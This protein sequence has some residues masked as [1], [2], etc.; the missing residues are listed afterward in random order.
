MVIGR[1]TARDLGARTT[2]NGQPVALERKDGKFRDPAALAELAK[3]CED[4]VAST[5]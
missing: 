4:M 3:A 1:E 2:E 5:S